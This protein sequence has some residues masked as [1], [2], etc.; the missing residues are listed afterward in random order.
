MLHFSAKQIETTFKYSDFIPFLESFYLNEITTP[1]RPHYTI[2]TENSSATLLLMP[3]WQVHQYIGIKIV[4]VFPEND[5][6]NLPSVQGVYILMD[7]NNGQLLATFDGLKLTV[8][9]TAAMSA[10]ANKLVSNPKL[11]NMLMIGTGNL[12]PELVQ[13]HCSVR[14]IREVFIWGRNTKKAEEKK[15]LLS[16]LL[17]EIRIQAVSD[18]EEYYSRSSLISAATLSSEALVS[19]EK[20][21]PGTHIDLVGS[22]LPHARETDDACLLKSSIFVDNYGALKESGDLYI[23]LQDGTINKSDVLM[24]LNELVKNGYQRKSKEENTLFKSVGNAKADLALAV[25]LIE[26][27]K[28]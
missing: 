28:N 19:G 5:Q 9:R 25:Y 6:L 12:C 20:I 26:M 8:K 21:Q 4:N 3:C 24:D 22:F 10:L 7:A 11:H 15:E 16:V 27:H 14:P 18:K 2:P 23:P 17:P 13:A 1:Q